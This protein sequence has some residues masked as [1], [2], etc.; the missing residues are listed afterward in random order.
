[1]PC[2][3][4]LFFFFFNDTATTEIYTLS[5]HDALPICFSIAYP[6]RWHTARLTAA[7]ACLFFEPKPFRIPPNS[8]FTGTALEVQPM[9]QSYAWLI[10]TLSDPRFSL[11]PSG[12]GAPV[13]G[14]PATRLE[15]A[16]TGAGQ[17]NRGIRTCA[18]VIDRGRRPDFVIQT[19]HVAEASC[20]AKKP[21]VD[22]AVRTL[23]FLS[24]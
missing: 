10:R 3:F 21:I 9:Q 2:L 18:Y 7:G 23:R 1:M 16:A 6:A 8:D 20:A 12:S 14:Q 22:R 13:A 4:F 17:L 11:V 19:A 24:A 5:L 15:T